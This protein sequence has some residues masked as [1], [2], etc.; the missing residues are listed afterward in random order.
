MRRVKRTE[1]L[2]GH[3]L[4]RNNFADG[5]SSRVLRMPNFPKNT[6]SIFGDVACDLPFVGQYHENCENGELFHPALRTK[7]V[8]SRRIFSPGAFWCLPAEAFHP[9]SVCRHAFPSS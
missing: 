9:F 1:A 4:G 6:A 8:L 7:L 2:W 3:N 5:K